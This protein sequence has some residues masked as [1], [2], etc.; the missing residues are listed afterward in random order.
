MENLAA[1][2]T[3][4]MHLPLH[5]H[6]ATYFPKAVYI[7]DCWRGLIDI[8]SGR[9]HI[10]V[11]QCMGGYPAESIALALARVEMKRVARESKTGLLR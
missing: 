5:I 11:H 1:T 6:G 2:D 10:T 7:D 3:Y 8:V 4:R 9:G